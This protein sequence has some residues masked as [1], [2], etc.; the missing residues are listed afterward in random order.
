MRG[1]HKE[2]RMK[3][4]NDASFV[5]WGAEAG[6]QKVPIPDEHAAPVS[7]GFAF[8]CHLKLQCSL[9]ASLPQKVH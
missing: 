9:M 3:N 1:Q 7:A 6:T 2:G 5:R 4:E 8:H